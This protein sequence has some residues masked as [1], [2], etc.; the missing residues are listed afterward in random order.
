MLRG[1]R[2][3][4]ITRTRRTRGTSRRCGTPPL[5]RGRFQSYD[6][7]EAAIRG[8]QLPNYAFVEPD[9]GLL[10]RGNSQHPSQA[11]SRDEFLEGE[12]LIHRIYEALRS[13]PEVFKKTVFIITYDEHGGFYDHVPPPP[14]VAPDGRKGPG[15][16]GFELLGCRV[17]TVVISPW[18][19]RGQIDP[20]IYDHTSVIQ[21][22]RT[23][24]APSAK[25]LTQRDRRAHPLQGLI[26]TLATPRLPSDWPK[27]EAL[28]A[29]EGRA[30]EQQHAA[31]DHGEA[32]VGEPDNDL[33]EAMRVTRAGVALHLGSPETAEL[34][35]IGGEDPVAELFRESSIAP[36]EGPE[37]L[38]RL[39]LYVKGLSSGTGAESLLP[40]LSLPVAVTQ[41][42]DKLHRGDHAE[43][44]ELLGL[45]AIVRLEDRPVVDVAADGRFERPPAPWAHLGDD[46]IQ[47]RLRHAATCVG[48]IEV[49]GDPRI[50]RYAGTGFLL[51]GGLVMTN[52]HV[53]ELFAVSSGTGP[54]FRPSAQH[55]RQPV[56][57]V[58]VTP[59]PLRITA[60]VHIDPTWDMAL[61][62]VADAPADR[63]L[64][65]AETPARQTAGRVVAAIG[66]PAS[67]DRNDPIAQA[68]IFGDRYQVKRLAPG[69]IV[70][71]EHEVETDWGGFIGITHDCSTLGGNSGS[72]LV[73]VETGRVVG[74]HLGGRFL[75]ANFACP[76]AP[77]REIVARVGAE[78]P[79]LRT[80]IA[81]AP[82]PPARA[83]IDGDAIVREA[84]VTT[85]RLNLPI[86][87]SVRVGVPT[88][89]ASPAPGFVPARE[90]LAATIAPPGDAAKREAVRTFLRTGQLPRVRARATEALVDLDADRS[91]SAGPSLDDAWAD[92]VHAYRRELDGPDRFELLERMREFYKEPD[93][94]LD[95]VTSLLDAID[96]AVLHPE[97]FYDRLSPTSAEGLG[98][99]LKT[100]GRFLSAL[101]HRYPMRDASA[102]QQA[103]VA[104]LQHA[105][106]LDPDISINPNDHTFETADPGW[107]HLLF[108][109]IEQKVG[110][111]PKG[112]APFRDHA[113]SSARGFHYDGKPGTQRIALLADFGTG[114][115]HARHIARQLERHRYPDVFHLGDVYYG[116]SRGEF[117][118]YFTAPLDPVLKAGSRVWGLPENHELYGEGVAYLEWIDRER[119]AG[120][121]E[122]E[123][124]YFSVSY[125]HH[126]VVGVDV[127][128][129]GR[130]RFRH[131]R[132]RQ[133]LRDVIADRGGRTVIF[134]TGSAPWG[135]G[136][137]STSSLLHDVAS[138][139]DLAAID[140]WFWG[141]DHYAA[142]FDPVPGK[143]P[144]IGSCI[145]HGG[146]PGSRQRAGR[147]CFAPVRWIEAE[148][149]FPADHPIRTDIGNNGWCELTFADAGGVDLRYVDWLSIERYRV[150]LRR[151]AGGRLQVTSE[152]RPPRTPA[153]RY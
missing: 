122:Q 88:A 11:N 123:G 126:L 36:V 47:Q 140:L 10:G 112:L 64:D 105:Y 38:A 50:P 18:V 138:A 51:A 29:A 134:L 72:P 130:Q 102:A 82:T 6:K 42:V 110:R 49:P 121:I 5:R 100:A 44:H 8:D 74:L 143:A 152:A 107:W 104:A 139:I 124:S 132:S 93:L 148:P 1:R 14:T 95:D 101:V 153:S 13:T 39:R 125:D 142:L 67:D 56:R 77:L 66:Y 85:V 7:L 111:W 45:E 89:E 23:R 12:R 53:A 20:A 37:D 99:K 34:P 15:G 41:L 127:N 31:P 73:D 28:T 32:P 137:T 59:T 60:V 54:T 79:R 94:D 150:S 2:G 129:H 145:G 21:T 78:A 58:G 144:F 81:T 115:Y 71:T 35:S 70:T 120:R 69:M 25:P 76:A 63:Y 97:D 92:V 119:K 75:E 109:H 147:A 48:R 16:F 86:E 135:Y 80:T 96:E 87:I 114:R 55:E 98:D 90:T 9:Y 46:P 57:L 83:P 68:N 103:A 26:N 151:A 65:L 146:Y 113:Q 91:R 24:F 33:L 116:G 4:S 128:W 52:R 30:L 43:R 84:G 106:Q 131:E 19:K 27:T 118:R 22:L 117:D 62:R 17:P 141:D 149:R 133:W 40:D 61:L 3:A 136:S 108:E